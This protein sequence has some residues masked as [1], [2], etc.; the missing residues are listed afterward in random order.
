M[1]IA[2]CKPADV[3]GRELAAFL[4]RHRRAEIDRRGWTADDVEERLKLDWRP[5]AYVLARAQAE[6]V[7]FVHLFRIGESDLIEI[8]P[9]P[10]Q[11]GRAHV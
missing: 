4:Y 5:L 10:V 2:I 11:I 3:D 6:L 7:G 9:G 1:E 8:N